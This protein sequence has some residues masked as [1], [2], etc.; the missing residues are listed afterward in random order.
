MAK[1]IVIVY[2]TQQEYSAE[3]HGRWQAALDK[4]WNDYHVFIVPSQ[5]QEAVQI[6]VHN[7]KN[8]NSIQVAELKKK[9]LE[10]LPKN[11]TNVGED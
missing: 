11:A 7:C 4:K 3:L 8:L 6:E 1:P 10:S 9:I 2:F 5:R